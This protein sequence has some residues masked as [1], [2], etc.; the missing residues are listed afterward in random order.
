MK[1]K[2]EMALAKATIEGDDFKMDA[3][4]FDAI[5]GKA[6][7]VPAP[8][9]VRAHSPIKLVLKSKKKSD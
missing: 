1:K 8:K 7:R 3:D 2:E 4:A 9:T 6:L 5:M